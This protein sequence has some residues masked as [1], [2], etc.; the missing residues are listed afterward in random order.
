MKKTLLI[1]FD[2]PDEDFDRLTPEEVRT[3]LG[4]A[5]VTVSAFPLSADDLD[6]AAAVLGN[7]ADRLHENFDDESEIESEKCGTLA[8]RLNAVVRSLRAL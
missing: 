8:S 3:R 5:T 2:V 4:D 7:E 6:S 1:T